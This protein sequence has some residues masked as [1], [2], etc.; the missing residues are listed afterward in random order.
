MSGQR[1]ASDTTRRRNQ[2]TIYAD[3]VIQTT[4]F[5]A[6]LR[7]SLILEGSP[8]YRTA[9]AYKFIYDMEAGAKQ[10]T[11]AEQ[12][13]YQLSV[14]AQAGLLPPPVPPTPPAPAGPP[15]P[16]ITS[17]T[18]GNTTIDIAFTQA[19]PSSPIS[20]Y[21]YSLDGGTTY[22][23]CSPAVTTSP[24]SLTGLTNGTT[25]TILV[26]GINADG[27]GAA[28]NSLA[29]TPSTIPQPPTAVSAVAGNAQADISFTAPTDDGGSAIL[30]YTVTS[31]PGG[32]TATGT[33]PITVTGLT[34]GTPYTFTV[35][36]RNINGSSSASAAS[37]AVTPSTVPNAPT[38]V[39]ATGGNAQASVSFSAPA[40]NGGST[41]FS[42]TA[43]SS[44]GGFTATGTSPL[45][46]SGLSN[47]TAYT[48]TVVATNANG[49]SVASSASNSV[50]P[51]TVI[52]PVA[53]VITTVSLATTFMIVNFT[54]DMSNG[55]SAVTNYQ[56]S[57]DGGTTYVSFSPADA[58]SPVT[59]SLTSNTSAALTAN[60]T[61]QIR[62]RALNVDGTGAACANYS[63]TTM[64]YA[65]YR[66][67]AIPGFYSWTSPNDTTLVQYLVV[68]GGG[69]SGGTY[70]S[71]AVLGTVPVSATPLS[72]AFWIADNP[73][74][75]YLDGYLYSTNTTTSRV[76]AFPLQLTAS[77]YKQPGAATQP[78]NAWFA[79]PIVYQVGTGAPRVTNY[80]APSTLIDS[81]YNNNVS[82]G[83][84]GGAGGQV[85]YQSGS[86]ATVVT[87][88]TTYSISV[89]DGGV[90]GTAGSGTEAAGSAGLSSSFDTFVTSSGGSG[91]SPAH[92]TTNT[93]NG[94][95]SGGQGGQGQIISGLPW[96]LLGGQGGQGTTGSATKGDAITAGSGGAG[97]SLNFDG[98][99][100]RSF[101]AGGV[102]GLPNTVNSTVSV[103]GLG[104]GGAGT[105]ATVNSYSPGV[106][107][108]TGL[109]MIKF[110]TNTV[111]TFNYVEFTTTGTTTW[112]AP[113][114]CLSP[115]K[116]YII[117]AGGGGGGAYDVTGGG[118]GGAG[119]VVTGSYFATPGITYTLTVG[120]GGTGGTGRTSL[121][122]PF[123][124][125]PGSDGDDSQFDTLHNGPLA[126]GGS[127][128]KQSRTGGN[129]GGS[130]GSASVAAGG[131]G[132]GGGGSG[133]AG[134]G[135]SSGAGTSGSAG[136]AGT[137]GAGTSVTYGNGGGTYT[138]GVGG[139]GGRNLV[140]GYTVGAAGAANSG[141][142]GGGGSAGSSSPSTLQTVGGAGGSGFI[143]IEYYTI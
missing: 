12:T 123:V 110:F 43:T 79:T 14:L 65:Y 93:T 53:P 109:V 95:N 7:N 138:F 75:G 126:Y 5:Q 11:V 41:I 25:Y 30:D 51:S 40:F 21:E 139:A 4:G 37:S 73:G 31:S 78:F 67:Y 22:T 8:P 9:I 100:T 143:R 52:L 112:T 54:Q 42:Y 125:T 13:G 29:A 108:G 64:T 34:N 94:Y 141:N 77:T 86:T 20:N 60:T 127:G 57:T 82:G 136:I 69:G 99:I 92:T 74:G 18:P 119:S 50:T 39:V 131:G 88:S 118:G 80:N 76:N 105:G 66:A 3:K 62:L 90:G 56:Y 55:A 130:A 38:S 114:N 48:F 128:G 45:T 113:S 121:S 135:G 91:G 107:G 17:L 71:L 68:G 98:T 111:A 61:Y 104:I 33:S 134:G 1:D 137:G 47:G 132:G 83:S 26:R 44:P 122:P 58:A 70:S 59:I 46:V 84:G 117:G 63:V 27:T 16:V 23:A 96:N 28:S 133:G 15:A 142:G 87:T 101:G 24:I 106:K 102:G 97:T 35:T 115:L 124:N 32:F 120:A 129:A 19:T 81:T 89:G 85:K 72:S 10:T 6:N 36:A 49:N 2:R 140:T 103:A 116:Y